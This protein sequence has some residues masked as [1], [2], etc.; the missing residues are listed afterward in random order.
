[1]PAKKREWKLTQANIDKIVAL[2]KEHPGAMKPVYG[3]FPGMR[4]DVISSVLSANG[5][6]NTKPE[7][8]EKDVAKVA[9]LMGQ[10]VTHHP[11]GEKSVAV[12]VPEAQ[13]V[14]GEDAPVEVQ[15]G[16]D[17]DAIEAAIA[18]NEAEAAKTRKQAPRERATKNA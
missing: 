9:R 14:P 7:V 6:I 11:R 12:D 1:M 17:N 2:G 8:K 10:D 16:T 15:P 5:L 3:A 18:A 13:E 4:E